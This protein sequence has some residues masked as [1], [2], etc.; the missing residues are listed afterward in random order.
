MP[1]WPTG[2]SAEPLR[3]QTMWVTTGTRRSGIDHH[4]QTVVESEGRHLGPA[5][6]GSPE[7]R[8]LGAERG[9]AGR[10]SHSRSLAH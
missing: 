8:R 9:G 3:Y 1:D 6:V 4:L 5:S 7:G 2:S 10:V